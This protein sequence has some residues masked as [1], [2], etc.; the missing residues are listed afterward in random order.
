[1]RE[2]ARQVVKHGLVLQLNA[3]LPRLE[4][5]RVQRA[6]SGADAVTASRFVDDHVLDPCL[7]S[8]GDAV[9]HEREAADDGPVQPGDEHD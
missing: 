5:V 7:D 6:T 8:G 4:Q 3:A 9:D 1:M 2:T